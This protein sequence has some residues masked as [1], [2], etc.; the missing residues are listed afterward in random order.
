MG[1]WEVCGK[2]QAAG[3]RQG[4]WAF[5]ELQRWHWTEVRMGTRGVMRAGLGVTLELE[6]RPRAHCQPPVALGP[7]LFF[8]ETPYS[9]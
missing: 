1:A 3:S 5:R 6:L 2:K 4:F 7:C 8:R 9:A